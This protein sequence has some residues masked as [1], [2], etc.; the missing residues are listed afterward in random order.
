MVQ[1]RAYRLAY[2]A[3]Y[4][5]ALATG[6][7]AARLAS[8]FRTLGQAGPLAIVLQFPVFLAWL[9]VRPISCAGVAGCSV[10]AARLS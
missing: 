8:D 4:F 6:V 2:R 10:L 1:T 9:V 7:V 5:L 3:C